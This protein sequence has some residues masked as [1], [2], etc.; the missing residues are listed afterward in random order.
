MC[1]FSWRISFNQINLILQLKTFLL[2]L[3]IAKSPI[4]GR[5]S[6]NSWFSVL[7]LFKTNSFLLMINI[8]LFLYCFALFSLLVNVY[9]DNQH[10]F[11]KIHP[12][13]EVYLYIVN[14]YKYSVCTSERGNLRDHS[15]IT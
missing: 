3:Y 12:I 4:L 13:Q 7:P 8:W 15:Y 14:N 5:F 6:G 10:C 11:E 1:G 2:L 9:F